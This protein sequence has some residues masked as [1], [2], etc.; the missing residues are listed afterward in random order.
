MFEKMKER[1]RLANE[2]RIAAEKAERERLMQLSEKELLVEL[3]M[4]TRR[5]NENVTECA[6]DISHTVRMWSN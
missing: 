6:E 4:E 3:L 1:A 5:L 2:A